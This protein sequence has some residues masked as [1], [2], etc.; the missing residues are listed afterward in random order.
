MGSGTAHAAHAARRPEPAPGSGHLCSLLH[1]FLSRD[2]Y[3]NTFRAFDHNL[4]EAKAKAD[5]FMQDYENGNSKGHEKQSANKDKAKACTVIRPI[6]AY[7][8]PPMVSTN[9]TRMKE[10]LK[11]QGALIAMRP[12]KRKF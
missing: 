10:Q 2:R 4:Q 8:P 1:L 11:V 12:S 6:T 5:L 3:E 7:V 9:T